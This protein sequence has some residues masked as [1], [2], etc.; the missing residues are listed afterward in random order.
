MK[1]KNVGLIVLGIMSVCVFQVSGS[2]IYEQHFDSAAPNSDDPP[3]W[4][5]SNGQ[6]TGG[7]AVNN[8]VY[9]FAGYSD[10]A[11]MKTDPNGEWNG[12]ED[13]YIV[14]TKWSFSGYG[15]GGIL[16]RVQ[17]FGTYYHLRYNN[18]NNETHQLELLRRSNYSWSTLDT[19]TIATPLSENTDYY[20]KFVLNGNQIDGYIYADSAMT[21][22]LAEVHAT[23]SAISSGKVGVR[24]FRASG[25]Y[26]N[27]IDDLIVS[28]IPEPTSMMSLLIGLG[29]LKFKRN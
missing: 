18:M 16:A 6:S 3:G 15:Y 11:Y 14:T 24:T 26:G 10:A 8:G 27:K 22:L 5:D 7:W 1:K 2:I 25:T 19:A 12:P 21:Q 20:L 13:N 4:V 23:D 17:D 28:T 9:S 29:L